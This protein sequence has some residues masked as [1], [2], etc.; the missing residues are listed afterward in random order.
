M[1][2]GKMNFTKKFCQHIYT[3]HQ[4]DGEIDL[5]SDCPPD[6]FCQKKRCHEGCSTSTDCSAGKY[7]KKSSSRCVQVS[8][9]LRLHV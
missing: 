1:C 4:K 2:T 5:R 7:C 8:F 6:H 3:L 9:S